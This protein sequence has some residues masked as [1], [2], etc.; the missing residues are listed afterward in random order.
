MKPRH[1]AALALVGWYLMIPPTKHPRSRDLWRWWTGS[2]NPIVNECNLDAPLSEWEESKEYETLSVCQADQT[3][4]SA[5]KRKELEEIDKAINEATTTGEIRDL[6]GGMTKKQRA[7]FEE[8]YRKSEE[9][10]V[11]CAGYARCVASDDPRLAK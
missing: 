4:A 8:N 2:D 6:L 3:K 1:A 5:T 11:E 10:E 9:R 7:N